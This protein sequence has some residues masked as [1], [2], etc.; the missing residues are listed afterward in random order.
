MPNQPMTGELPRMS[1]A[2]VEG[3]VGWG[4]D[5]NETLQVWPDGHGNHRGYA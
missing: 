4:R 2:A 1:R 5:G 3:E